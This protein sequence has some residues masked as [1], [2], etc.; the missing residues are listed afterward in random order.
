MPDVLIVEDNDLTAKSLAYLLHK[1]GF[2]IVP[3]ENGREACRLLD[4][5]NFDVVVTD[6]M[7]PFANG[8]EVI[9]HIRSNPDRKDLPIIVVT[10]NT[11]EK[12]RNEAYSLGIDEYITKP[13]S[14][15]QLVIIMKKHVGMQ[16]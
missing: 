1:E 11:D 15:V 6:L 2:T 5:F 3:A 9:R 7:M 12:S 16:W 13:I 4:Q 10:S 14:P 8:F